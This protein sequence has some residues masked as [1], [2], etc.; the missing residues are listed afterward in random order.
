MELQTIQASHVISTCLV[1]YYL[2]ADT[3]IVGVKA[4]FARTTFTNFTIGFAI[5]GFILLVP[6]LVA[7]YDSDEKN[8]GSKNWD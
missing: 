5:T 6:V 8:K 3:F 4:M 2:C 1:S 7:A